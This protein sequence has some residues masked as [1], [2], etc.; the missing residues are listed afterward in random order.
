MAGLKFERR[1]P[2]HDSV[3]QTV[4]AHLSPRSTQRINPTYQPVSKLTVRGD[5]T[6]AEEDDLRREDGES[7]RPSAYRRIPWK[8][9]SIAGDFYALA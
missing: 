5:S 7:D 6:S 1:A 3:G 8:R 2:L 4:N 9:I